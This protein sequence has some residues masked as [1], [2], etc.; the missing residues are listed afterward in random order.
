MCMWFFGGGFCLFRAAPM[1]YGGSWARG[2]IGA[3]LAALRH[4]QAMPDPSLVCDLHHSS[5]QC[6]IHNPPSEARD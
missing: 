3:L 5:Q 1:V 2:Q 6:Q 4:S